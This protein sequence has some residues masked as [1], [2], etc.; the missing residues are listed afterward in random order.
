[1]ILIDG[2]LPGG[3]NEAFLLPIFKK[4]NRLEA[5][6]YRGVA[7]SSVILK[8]YDQLITKRL[9]RTVEGTI[10]KTQ[11]GFNKERSIITNHIE[12]VHFI[13]KAQLKKA[14]VDIIY[15]DFSRAFDKLNHLILMK[16]LIGMGIPER[17]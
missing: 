5:N 16:K 7:I 12:T 3:W 6:N 1:M 14:S 8:I 11:Q 9:Y 4:G 15:F 17:I 10:S 13:Q 2:R